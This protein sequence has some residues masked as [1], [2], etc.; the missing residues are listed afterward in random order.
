MLLLCLLLL[1][2]HLSLSQKL[3]LMQHLRVIGN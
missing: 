2:H 1:K 3:L